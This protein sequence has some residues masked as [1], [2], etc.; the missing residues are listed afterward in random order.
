MAD[1]LVLERLDKLIAIT[2]LAHREAIDRARERILGDDAKK[3]MI[4]MAS[5]WTAAGDLKTRAIKESRESSATVG[6]RLA[7]LVADGV[8]A[9]RGGGSNVSYKAT[10]LI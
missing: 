4:E 3:A 6:R 8:L 5:D 2:Q 7:E 1:D 9:K 10:G